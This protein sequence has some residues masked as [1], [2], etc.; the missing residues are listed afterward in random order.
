MPLGVLHVALLPSRQA[1]T[2]SSSSSNDATPNQAESA[3]LLLMPLL[4][5]PA[6][7]AHELQQHWQ[8]AAAAAAD[9]D[10]DETTCVADVWSKTIAPLTTDIAYLLSA[11]KDTRSWPIAA[12][13]AAGR[14]PEGLRMV[15]QQLLTHLAACGMWATMQQLVQIA[16]EAA[17]AAA[18]ATGA[19]SGKDG[20]MNADISSCNSAVPV[21]SPTATSSSSSSAVGA[22]EAGSCSRSSSGP[23]KPTPSPAAAAAA[24]TLSATSSSA[25]EAGS[26]SRSSSGP[27]KPAPAAAAATGKPHQDQLQLLTD[28]AGRSFAGI[29]VPATSLLW[30]FENPQLEDCYQAAA[31]SS[32]RAMDVATLVYGAAVGLSCYSARGSSS[33]Q[34]QQQLLLQHGVPGLLVRSQIVAMVVCVVGP[35]AVLAHRMRVALK[36]QAM[37]QQQQQQQGARLG[38]EKGYR[39]S[40]D[41]ADNPS[42]TNSNSSS[43]N[44]NLSSSRFAADVQAELI[45]AART[46]HLLWSCWMALVMVWGFMILS[47]CFILEPVVVVKQWSRVGWADNLGA[48]VAWALKGWTTQ[49]RF[50]FKQLC[51]SLRVL[52]CNINLGALVA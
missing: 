1:D 41:S 38:K 10:A 51:C 24:E 14:L 33:Q 3:L 45:A 13:A 37:Q 43:G 17:A 8:Q 26:C 27:L 39:V 49:V 22:Y 5:L 50:G 46:N 34:L 19:V 4:V 47:G 18:A 2:S 15:L 25:F 35:L 11:C 52:F 12:A 23:F 31:F 48:L 44:A 40:F 7:A 30:G 9:D 20:E 16:T 21:D 28:A 36:L 29:A 42:S 32:S 6:A